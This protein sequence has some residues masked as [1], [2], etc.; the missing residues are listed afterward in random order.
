MIHQLVHDLP[1]W[2]VRAYKCLV[3]PGGLSNP[4]LATPGR[5]SSTLSLYHAIRDHRC[6]M[7]D[8]R[9]GEV[10]SAPACL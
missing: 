5:C 6:D 4:V 7:T 2:P 9:Q 8:P 1:K 3:Q 10:T